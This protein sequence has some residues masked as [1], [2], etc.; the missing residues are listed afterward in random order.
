MPLRVLLV[1]DSPSDAK[2]V[3][4]ALAPEGHPIEVE[5]VETADSMRAALERQ[6]WDVVISDW[7]MPKFSA[8]AALEVLRQSGL[9]LPF[10]IVSGTVGEEHA[11]A[12]MRAGA[13]DYVLKDKLARLAPAVER[14]LREHELRVAHRLA[15]S[16]R[17]EAEQRMRRIIDSSMVGAWFFDAEGNTTFMNGRMAR[18]LG[19]TAEEAPHARVADFMEDAA[20]SL[21][22][23]RIAQRRAGI[24]GNYEQ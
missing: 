19:L 6:S 21:A 9:D 24:S 1:E 20:G 15:E 12:A 11:V 13:H 10:I 18:M 3:A 8:L 23:E 14:E 2:L 17:L 22:A 4:R 5:R 7:S 16:A